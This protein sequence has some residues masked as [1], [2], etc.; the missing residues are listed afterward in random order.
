MIGAIGIFLTSIGVG[1]V[2]YFYTFNLVVK[3]AED[4]IK[5][6]ADS[7]Q[8]TLYSISNDWKNVLSVLSQKEELIEYA[9]YSYFKDK[10]KTDELRPNIEKIFLEYN[11]LK[12]HLI[13]YIR[14]IDITGKEEVLVKNGKISRKYKDRNNRRYFTQTLEQN[15]GEIKQP[16]YRKGKDYF[17]L[18]WSIVLGTEKQRYGVLVITFSL[19]NILNNSNAILQ[20]GIIDDY[21]WLDSKSRQ[22]LGRDAQLFG[23]LIVPELKLG[24]SPNDE[25]TA[26]IAHSSY[27]PELNVHA[28]LVKYKTSLNEQH[29]TIYKPILYLNLI[30]CIAVI[31]LFYILS[32]KVRNN[33]SQDLIL[34]HS[35]EENVKLKGVTTE[36][37]KALEEA[38]FANSA[39]SEFLSNMSHELRTPIHAILS[40]SNFGAK[41]SSVSDE[42][43]KSYFIKIHKSG[44][45][46]LELLNDL[47][48]LS[49]LESGKMEFYLEAHNV[50]KLLDDCIDELA[51]L[52]S[53]KKVNININLQ[54]EELIAECDRTSLSQVIRNLLSN[55]IK[56]T[57]ENTTINISIRQNEE[58][59]IVFSIQDEGIGI[60]DDELES[61]FDKFIQSS[62]TKNGSGGTGLGLSICSQIMEAH[63][64]TIWAEK[65]CTVGAKFIFELPLKQPG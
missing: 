27:I 42:K 31:G 46:L 43:R 33:T 17:A 52:I 32:I 53:T 54:R 2:L 48:D 47:L 58:Q 9:K 51:P 3:Q 24:E 15:I 10:Q 50:K 6:I 16:T 45:N 41:K 34:Q 36:L 14:F 64:G 22:I 55:A 19:S 21:Y 60:P 56:F 23:L 39:K 40:Y 11:N 1:L 30:A 26:N 8:K 61:V 57:A 13:K 44:S 49:K 59:S 4:R 63:H 62:K 28:V 35:I 18:D 20:S 65:N 7:E 5:K 29:F 25:L 38:D 37:N 12:P